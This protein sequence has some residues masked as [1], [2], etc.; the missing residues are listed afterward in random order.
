MKFSN[1]ENKCH[2][3]I[4]GKEIW[5]SRSI[6]VVGMILMQHEGEIY[7]ILGKRGPASPN[8][9]GKWCMPCGYLDWNETCEEAVVREVWEESGFNCYKAL[10][11]YDIIHDHMHFP[12][13]INS[14][15][16]TE[17]QNVSMHYALYLDSSPTMYRDKVALPELTIEH[18]AVKDEVS[19]VKWVNVSDLWNY[20]MA[21]NHD[22]TIK[23]FV[24]NLPVD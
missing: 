24:N 9:I 4:E 21:F 22:S 19:L 17:I 2:I 6:A 3:T 23:I 8:E 10:D 7:V 12:W 20:D 14:V 16:D 5:K 11:Q 15:P 1:K 13:K 18:N